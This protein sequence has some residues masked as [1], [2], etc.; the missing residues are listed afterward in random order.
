MAGLGDRRR[1]VLAAAAAAL[2]TCVVLA[3]LLS[4]HGLIG[5]SGATS[6]QAAVD[7]YVAAIRGGDGAEMAAVLGDG[8]SA[9]ARLDRIRRA[10][11][12]PV[13]VT[14]VTFAEMPSDE[15]KTVVLRL[16]DGGVRSTEEVLA[17]PAHD[18]SQADPRHWQIFLVPP[19]RVSAR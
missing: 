2:T 12:H 7:R 10:D 15:W 9:R 14:E 1:R 4:A 17:G 6:I 5:H 16:D 8:Y 13:S 11:G 19:D 3:L 18:E